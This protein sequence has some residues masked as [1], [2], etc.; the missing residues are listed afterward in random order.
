MPQH[1]AAVTEAARFSD[2]DTYI[3]DFSKSSIWGDMED[4]DCPA[5]RVEQLGEIWDAYHR[6]VKDIAAAAG[7]SC[8]KLAERFCIPY[9]T[10]EDW[11]AGKSACPVYTRLM[12]Q[13][14]LGMYNPANTEQK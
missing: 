14:C 1:H 5:T 6:N 11:S 7:L 4:A 10:M 3:S 2:R 9:R 13:E 8:R 12:M